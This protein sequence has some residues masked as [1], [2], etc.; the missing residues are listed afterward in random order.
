MNRRKIEGKRLVTT[1]ILLLFCTAILASCRKSTSPTE[2]TGTDIVSSAGDLAADFADED[3]DSNWQDSSYVEVALSGDSASCDASGVS[4]SDSIITISAA[5]TYVFS[6]TLDDGQIYVDTSDTSSVRIVLNGADISCSDSSAIYVE[7]AE[8]TIVI[9]SDDTENSLSDGSDYVLADEEEGEPDAA[10]FCKSDLTLTGGGALTIQAN[11]NHG[12]VSKDDLKITGGTY[13]ITSVGDGIRGRDS[14]AIED[15]DITITSGGDGM[16]SNNDEDTTKGY[17]IILSGTYNITSVSD[18]IQAETSLLIN[19]GDFTIVSGGGSV[20]AGTTTSNNFESQ[21]QDMVMPGKTTGDGTDT[22][23][24]VLAPD[25]MPIGM[26]TD[27]ASDTSTRPALPASGDSA[28]STDTVLAPSDD[29]EAN[30]DTDTLPSGNA[31]AVTG[32]TGVVASTTDTSVSAKGLKAGVDLSVTG[33]TFLINSADDT[34]HA[35]NNVEIDAGTFSLASGDDGMHA[36]SGLLINDGEISISTSYEGLEGSVITIN[37]GTIHIVASDDG[38]NV[39]GGNDSSSETGPMGDQGEFAEDTDY[40]LYI[41][42][43]YMVIDAS[44]DGLDTNGSAYMTDGIVIVSG[45]TNAG[46]GA[47]DYAGEFVVSGGY[48]VAVGSVGMAQSESSN[49]SINCV[50]ISL[51][52]VQEAGTLIRIEDEDGNSIL[53]YS[54]AKQYQSIVL[55]TSELVSGSTYSIS[56]GG[57][58]DGTQEDGFYTDGTYSGGTAVDTFTVADTITTIGTAANTIGGGNMGGNTG[59]NMGGGQGA[60]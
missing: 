5:G 57:S 24:D 34:I 7:S 23:S 14:I 8:K 12:I 35:G 45:P 30:T 54:P 56:V 4:I 40:Y 42:G 50:S 28:A 6:G 39:A 46:N 20:S 31:Q 15:A 41:S 53:T 17:I 11:Y 16:Q 13:T 49:S 9:L 59:G 60:R 1:L 47:L 43:G 18:G 58:S 10:I 25:D 51:D 48:L 21:D 36:D 55:C 44:G 37:D 26:D 52:S 3:T 2:T 38:V 27:T 22:S 29:A 33:G 19:G 32:D